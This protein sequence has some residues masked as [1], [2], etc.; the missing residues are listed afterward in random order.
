MSP[1]FVNLGHLS[2]FYTKDRL[3]NENYNQNQSEE[4]MLV[5][6]M[7]LTLFFITVQK[8]AKFYPHGTSVF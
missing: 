3:N 1:I 7:A 4:P 5:T 2:G 8:P 6:T